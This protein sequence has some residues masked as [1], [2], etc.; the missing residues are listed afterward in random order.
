MNLRL[1][2]NGF[3]FLAI[4]FSCQ[5]WFDRSGAHMSSPASH[6]EHMLSMLHNNYIA[7]TTVDK[8]APA[9]KVYLVIWRLEFEIYNGGLL[10][11][12]MNSSGAFVPYL[13]DAL[14]TVSATDVLPIIEEA[15]AVVGP[16]VP[17]TDDVKR[18][19][20]I[21]NLSDEVRDRIWGLDK[22][23]SDHLGKLS[24][25]LL[26]YVSRN[27]DQFGMSEEFWK[28]AIPQ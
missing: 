11:F 24:I 25:L 2:K 15:V 19:H 21:K 7:E 5:I 10:Q 6:A 22:R 18:W 28:E 8:L 13:N 3:L 20:A 26:G 23:L 14:S 1:P 16:D 9:E 4:V 12:F 17:W 27:R